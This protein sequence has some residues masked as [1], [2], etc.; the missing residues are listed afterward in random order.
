M[1]SYIFRLV[2]DPLTP[3]LLRPRAVQCLRGYR[4]AG[5]A[6]G[7]SV[8]VANAYNNFLIK[9]RHDLESNQAVTNGLAFWNDVIT[10]GILS[11]CNYLTCKGVLS[12]LCLILDASL[13]PISSEDMSELRMTPEEAK[14]L[15]HDPLKMTICGMDGDKS[16]AAQSLPLIDDLVRELIGKW[17]LASA[18]RRILS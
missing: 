2:A 9:W 1:E 18:M 3:E 12:N 14:S 6:P 5:L 11:L 16:E 15:V 10:A 13:A 7:A 8:D 17:A 4:Y